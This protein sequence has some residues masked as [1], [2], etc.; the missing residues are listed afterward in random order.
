MTAAL[1][2]GQRMP[3][4][5]LPLADHAAITAYAAASGDDNPL[6][7]DIETAQQA[8]FPD[9]LVPGLMVQGQ[10]AEVLAQWL[11]DA[12]IDAFEAR[13]V[14]P[15]TAGSPLRLEGRVAAL[16]ADGVAILRLK[17]MLG[18]QVAVLGEAVI[19]QG[20]SRPMQNDL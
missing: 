16:R 17:A 18:A 2:Q 12:R 11:P 13:F 8:G 14:L 5:D 4:T 6:H 19:R 20:H 9:V 7:Q 3:T 10:M 1:S 15:V